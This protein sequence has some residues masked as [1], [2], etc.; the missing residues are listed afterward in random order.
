[1]H[2]FGF[3]K[4]AEAGE[5][6]ESKAKVTNGVKSIW[7]ML[8]ITFGHRSTHILAPCRVGTDDVVPVQRIRAVQ[9]YFG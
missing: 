8:I 1:M 6:S 5:M 3:V 7:V 9:K 4:V 2:D